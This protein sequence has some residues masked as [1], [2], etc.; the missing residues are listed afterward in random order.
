MVCLAIFIA[1]CSKSS[2]PAGKNCD[3]FFSK[4]FKILIDPILAPQNKGIYVNEMRTTFSNDK[5]D[6]GL[7]MNFAY[8]DGK[9][10]LMVNFLHTDKSICL[11]AGSPLSLGYAPE[12]MYILKGRHKRN[13]VYENSNN[14]FNHYALGLYEL[15]INS[16]FFKQLLLKGS[17]I[18][19]S[20]DTKSNVYTFKIMN[21]ETSTLLSN[22][23]RCIYETELGKQ[24]DIDSKDLIDNNLN[25][26]DPSTY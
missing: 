11:G 7:A 12:E 22:T 10:L 2:V 6:S 14:L 23:A 13:C 8:R 17:P 9:V 26:F 20:I 1:S 18:F 19:A 15:P 4:D 24:I 25:T 3:V 5:A 21:N 16:V